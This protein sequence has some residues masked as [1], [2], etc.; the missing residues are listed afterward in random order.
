VRNEGWGEVD[1]STRPE[2]YIDYLRGVSAL[3][4][5]QG[6]KRKSLEL[7]GVG[8]GDSVLDVGCGAGDEVVALAR[9]VG[10]S[11]HAVGLDMSETMVAEGRRR[12]AEA[13]VRAEF[14]VGD[15]QALQFEDDSFDA[16]RIER[17][18]QHL[19]DPDRALRELRRVCRPGGRVVALDPDW[20]SL[21]IDSDDEETSRRVIRAHA[22]RV[23]HGQMGRELW[24]RFGVVGFEDRVIESVVAHST[25]FGV[26]DA[27]VGLREA[28][29]E[30]V[31][32]GVIDRSAGD[33][34]LD[35]L[36]TADKNGRFFGA[37]TG[38]VVAGRT[39]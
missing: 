21:V 16:A 14:K 2:S 27:V 32:D 15:A 8:T 12:A 29:N 9:M 11:G 5:V 6:F 28:V 36:R 7:M 17:T 3:D 33:R 18:L 37:L 35:G 26:A 24:R 31:R 13:G 4:S 1:R 23:T 25:S 30:A 34:W 38:F 22:A 20:S 10:E 39:P 19:P